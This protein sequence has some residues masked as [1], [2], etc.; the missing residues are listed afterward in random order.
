MQDNKAKK[1]S[2][3]EL[4]MSSYLP[5]LTTNQKARNLLKVVKKFLINI[6]TCNK[7]LN[8]ICIYYESQN[9]FFS[10]NLTLT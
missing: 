3:R 6:Y 10:R 8:D 1:W 7:S 5:R 4:G 9:E 2:A